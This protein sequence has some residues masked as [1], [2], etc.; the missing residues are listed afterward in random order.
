MPKKCRIWFRI[1]GKRTRNSGRNGQRARVP[2]SIPGKLYYRRW[3]LIRRHIR[4]SPT[5]WADRWAFKLQRWVG[6]KILETSFLLTSW[7]L[8]ELED[9]GDD[10]I[11]LG[12]HLLVEVKTCDRSDDSF[13]PKPVVLVRCRHLQDLLDSRYIRRYFGS[14]CI[15]YGGE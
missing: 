8:E 13:Q 6:L 11:A 3:K 15:I 5:S 14:D 1:F 10:D 4:T 2:C 7:Y 9:L 12:S